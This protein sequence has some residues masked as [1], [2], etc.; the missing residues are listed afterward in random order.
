LSNRKIQIFC[1]AHLRKQGVAGQFLALLPKINRHMK[2]FQIN[3][4]A[5]ALALFLGY[6]DPLFVPT[7]GTAEPSLQ[8]IV[9][10]ENAP[11]I[12]AISADWP[13]YRSQLIRFS[14]TGLFQGNDHIQGQNLSGVYSLVENVKGICV[15]TN[16]GTSADGKYYVTTGM[17]NPD[18]YFDAQLFEIDPT[19]SSAN[20][21]GPPIVAAPGT[22]RDICFIGSFSG[23]PPGIYGIRGGNEL[24]RFGFN[25]SSGAFSA[26]LSVG[27]FTGTLPVG[28]SAWGLTWTLCGGV[29]ELI[30]AARGAPNLVKYYKCNPNTAVLTYVGDILPTAPSVFSLAHCGIGWFA[31]SNMLMVNGI[32]PNAHPLT[33]YKFNENV[34]SPWCPGVSALVTSVKLPLSGRNIEDFCTELY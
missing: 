13:A 34:V 22:I 18:P 9:T 11:F 10:A 32:D 12:Y 2:I 16:T 4:A 30:I 33:V 1:P 31:S 14:P 5:V 29:P 23:V 3:L 25:T 19:S 7:G 26:P 6:P 8:T 17:S 24:V 27:F 28:F 21:L 20:I 15:V